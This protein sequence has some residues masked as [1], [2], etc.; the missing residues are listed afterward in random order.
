MAGATSW[1]LL[2]LYCDVVALTDRAS[3][4]ACSIFAPAAARCAP[5]PNLR[6][7]RRYWHNAKVASRS[8]APERNL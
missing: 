5:R 8:D 6:I 7:A 2:G 1:L 3:M 4:R